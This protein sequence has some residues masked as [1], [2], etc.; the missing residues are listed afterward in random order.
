MRAS[1]SAAFVLLLTA[2]VAACARPVDRS[3]APSPKTER[4]AGAVHLAVPEHPDPAAHYVFYLHGAIIETQGRRPT[5]PEY[6]VY[7]YDQILDTLADRGF[8]VISEARPAGTEVPAYAMKVAAQVRALVDAGVPGDHIAVAGHSKGAMI[9]LG[10]SSLLSLP[11]DP[12]LSGVRYVVMAGCFRGG[13]P[14]RGL[15]LS[16][17]VLSIVDAADRLAGSCDTV[18]SH[19]AHP[20]DAADAD[21]EGQGPAETK[22]ITLHT[23]LGHGAFYRPMD[24]WLDPLTAWIRPSAMR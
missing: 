13:S 17:H 4:P 8:Q 19:A 1:A 22:E 7:E 18:F 24:E 11:D 5:H 23:G 9:T 15:H 14:I 16:G 12:A 21:H 20:A 6:G 10:V 2:S 3:T